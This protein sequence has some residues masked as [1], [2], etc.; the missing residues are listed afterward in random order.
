MSDNELVKF[1][2][3][4]VP[5]NTD[6]LVGGLSNVGQTLQGSSGD[7]PFLKIKNGYWS[8]G[9]ENIEPEPDSP[10][11]VNPYS[12]CHG[13]VCWGDG[14]LLDERMVP[15]NQTPPVRSDLPDYGHEWAQQVSMLLQ[16]LDGEDKG[17]QVSYKNSSVGGRNAVKSLID[18]II[19]QA[20][21]DPDHIVP[22]IELDVRSYQHSKYGETFNPVFRIVRWISIH[23]AED[24][25][26]SEDAEPPSEPAKAAPEPA[27]PRRRR[28]RAAAE[29][30]PETDSEPPPQSS[31]RRRRRRAAS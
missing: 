11:A 6:D 22:V 17:L 18:D 3:G 28:R 13:F 29:S 26:P 30:E 12:L 16:C 7:T 19:A 20:Q 8:Y 14:D 23:D 25:A 2:P 15:F 31:N 1:G 4:G 21:H 9:Q 10:W 27:Q 24:A 5:M